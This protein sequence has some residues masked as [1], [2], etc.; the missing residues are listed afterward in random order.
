[1]MIWIE[2]LDE[3]SGLVRPLIAS[4]EIQ[5]VAQI[6][7]DVRECGQAIYRITQETILGI[8]ARFRMDTAVIH[9]QHARDNHVPIAGISHHSLELLPIACVESRIVEARVEDVIG[10][11][12]RPGGSVEGPVGTYHNGF[13]IEFV[14]PTCKCDPHAIDLQRV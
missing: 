6:P 5:I 13:P 3:D 11:L 14:G 8:A 12:R 7:C 1:M 2:F 4:E 9:V 10:L